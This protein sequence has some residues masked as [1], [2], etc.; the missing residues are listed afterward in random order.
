MEWG[1]KLYGMPERSRSTGRRCGLCSSRW[2]MGSAVMSSLLPCLRWGMFSL[3]DGS[4]C[5]SSVVVV[6]VAWGGCDARRCARGLATRWTGGVGATWDC[7]GGDAAGCFVFSDSKARDAP[8]SADWL[9]R[10]RRLKGQMAMA[11]R[12]C[13]SIRPRFL[14]HPGASQALLALMVV[15]DG[16]CWCR[17]IRG[18]SCA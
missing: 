3:L 16:F 10:L 7:G 8:P 17:W 14:A 15:A 1:R 2:V 11:G 4:L 9:G 5:F 13:Q 6:G 12:G 18:F